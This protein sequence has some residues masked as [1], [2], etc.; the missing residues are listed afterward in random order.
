MGTMRDN[1]V[2]Q[3]AILVIASTSRAISLRREEDRQEPKVAEEGTAK[4]VG[5][6]DFRA[7]MPS[8]MQKDTNNR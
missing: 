7:S 4:V 6:P 3:A 2:L 1:V 8:M 5:G